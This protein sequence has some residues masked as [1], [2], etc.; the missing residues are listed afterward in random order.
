MAA[1]AREGAQGGVPSPPR[2]V[3]TALALAIVAATM[4]HGAAQGSTSPV[5]GRKAELQHQ[6]DS[7]ALLVS[8]CVCV[9]LC[10]MV[11]H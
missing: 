5:D 2:H 4:G 6:T 7:F 10:A 1:A 3:G 8:E 9:N 11:V